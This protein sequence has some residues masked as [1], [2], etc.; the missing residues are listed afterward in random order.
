[1]HDM[2]VDY[3]KIIALHKKYAPSDA[4]YQLVWTHCCIVRD[5]SIQ[6]P[7]KN[8]LHL[9]KELVEVG[10]L[11]H[12]IGVYP[13]F[14]AD[15]QLRKGVNYITHGTEGERILALE[16]MPHEVTR[17]AAHH[18]GVGLTR[19]DIVDQKLP[20]PIDDYLAE[21]DEE[22][23]IMYADKFHSKTT[24]PFFNSFEWYRGDIA[25]FGKDKVITFDSMASK[26]GKPD[27]VALSKKYGFE[28]R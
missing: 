10:A 28:I 6:L 12:D 21:T 25:K 1:M 18:T 26:F 15:G 20:L 14:G 19:Q 24:P 11:L 17:F 23:L 5:I 4:V 27:L 3:N 13:L 7:E 8:G 22:L 2:L 9:D 16:N